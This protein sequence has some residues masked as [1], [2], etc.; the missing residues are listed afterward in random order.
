MLKIKPFLKSGTHLS[1]CWSRRQMALAHAIREQDTSGDLWITPL[2]T[3][4]IL[5]NA[6]SSVF[7]SPLMRQEDLEIPALTKLGFPTHRWLPPWTQTRVSC[8]QSGS[9]V[10]PA[11]KML[12]SQIRCK[13]WDRFLPLVEDFSSHAHL[14]IIFDTSTS[15]QQIWNGVVKLPR[16]WKIYWEV[17]MEERQGA[18]A[19]WFLKGRWKALDTALPNQSC[20]KRKKIKLFNRVL[21]D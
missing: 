17:K 14:G 12:Q 11:T 16:W 10:S 13:I 7:S 20:Q 21:L 9:K 19:L 2:Q 4:E 8:C 3:H 18:L 5:G 6:F 15:C 1:F